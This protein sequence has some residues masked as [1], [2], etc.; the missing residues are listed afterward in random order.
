M[1][2]HI[3]SPAILA[4]VGRLRGLGIVILLELYDTMLFLAGGPDVAIF[5]SQMIMYSECLI[6]I[7][8]VENGTSVINT[9]YVTCVFIKPMTLNANCII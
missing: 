1:G 4:S 6:S 9:S 3:A 5:R 8:F 7:F 2:A